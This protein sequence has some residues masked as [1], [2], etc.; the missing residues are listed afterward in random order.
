MMQI[1]VSCHKSFL[2]VARSDNEIL[3]V[4]SLLK[5]Q[6]FIKFGTFVPNFTVSQHLGIFVSQSQSS[7]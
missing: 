7:R 4:D 2:P 6:I 1:L 5:S 3:L